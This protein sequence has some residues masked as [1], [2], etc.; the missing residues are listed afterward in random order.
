MPSPANDNVM[1]IGDSTI[2]INGLISQHPSTLTG[3]YWHVPS[4]TWLDTAGI[5]SQSSWYP[6]LC[7]QWNSNRGRT[8]GIID[9]AESGTRILDSWNPDIIGNRLP[10]AKTQWINSGSPTLNA[11]ICQLG[12]ND[13]YQSSISAASAYR[14]VIQAMQSWIATN[15]GGA[16]LYFNLFADSDPNHAAYGGS[17]VTYRTHMD[18]IR[19]G[20]LDAIAAG[21]ALQGANLTGQVYADR[22]HPDSLALA[23]IHGRAWY[24]ALYGTAPPRMVGVSLNAAK[25]VVT[26]TLDRTL[27][28]AL[29]SSVA[30]F[31]VTDS[32]SLA[33]I[34]SAI[35]TTSRTVV[36]TLSAPIAGT[37]AVSFA[38][39]D[40]AVGVTLPVGATQTLVDASTYQA[41][42]VPFF[43]QT[44]PVQTN[45]AILI[46]HE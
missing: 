38:S 6:D 39:A 41:P 15:L 9:A 27:A 21:Y 23:A 33:T 17:L 5:G 16:P 29:S 45:A 8:L 26:V 35:V 44:T 12:V 37:C 25:T 13:S 28:N 20:I 36:L 3:Y 40:D 22:T 14:D 43:T 34:S 42:L 1:G 46:T 4:S 10:G 31:R 2:A 11:V 32:G 30:G 7:Q 24:L 18:T 19:Q